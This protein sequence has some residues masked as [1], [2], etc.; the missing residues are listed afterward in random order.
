MEPVELVVTALV[1]AAGK[2]LLDGFGTA[3]STAVGDAY[4]ALRNLVTGRLRGGGDE[5]P[6]QL[7]NNATPDSAEGRQALAAAL[8]QAQVDKPT[9]DAAQKLID[10]LQPGT[11]TFITDASNAKGVVIGNHSVQHNTFN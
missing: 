7:I 6:E 8:T 1:A 10:L 2:G 3:V 5:D 11:T 9:A 4:K